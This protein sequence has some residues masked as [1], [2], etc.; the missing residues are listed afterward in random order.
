MDFNFVSTRLATGGAISNDADVKI[1]LQSG[2]T[3][4]I[5]CRLEF[6]DA[7]LLKTYP[8]IKYL[9]NGVDDDGKPKSIIWFKTSI[10]FA[11]NALS[12][13][14][15]KVYCHCAAGID[16]GPS[17][18]FV[19]LRAL[20]LSSTQARDFIKSAKP[21]AQIGYLNDANAAIKALQYE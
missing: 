16:Q 14:L 10:D 18:A 1:L 4:I 3:H 5:N 19:V 11:L 7:Q 21:I 17:T 2:I 9:Y 6:D 13:P 8:Q 20:G 15:N 12:S